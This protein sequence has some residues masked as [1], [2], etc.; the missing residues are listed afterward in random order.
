MPICS[1]SKQFTCALL[2]EQFEDPVALD[3]H[4]RDF[5]PD[6]RDTL[7]TVE[8]LRHSQS[9]LREALSQIFLVFRAI[10]SGL[11][12]AEESVKRMAVAFKG[13]HF[14]KSIILHAALFYV[15]YP[16]S[17]RELQETTACQ[18]TR[19]DEIVEPLT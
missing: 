10:A 16:V 4:V 12:M 7:P 19:P 13:A 11:C 17:Y 2:L 1:L 6:Y 9:G 14:R 8:Q 15:R 18:R 3:L 5:I